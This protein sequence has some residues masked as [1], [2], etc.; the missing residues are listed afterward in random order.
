MKAQITPAIKDIINSLPYNKTVK[1]NAI[2]I[3]V[4]LYNIADTRSNKHGYFPVP[5]EYLTSINVRYYKIMEHF[6]E[7]GLLQQYKR[8]HQDPNDIFN[9]IERRYY[10]TSRGICMRYKF[11]LPTKGEIIEV[12]LEKNKKQFR[13]YDITRTSLEQL[14]YDVKISRDTFGRRVHHSAIQTYK[15][16][17]K[18]Q[19]YALIDAKCS[20]PKLLLNLM[21]EKGIEDKNYIEAFKFDFYTYLVEKLDLNDR[22][23]AK[24]LFMYFLN[25]GGYVPNYKIHN[26]FPQASRFVKSLKNNNYKDSS[27]YLQR[28]EA[29][30]WID[31]LLE[32]IPTDFGLPVH[33]CLI[34]K[35]KDSRKVL[36]YCKSK[37]NNID[38]EVSYL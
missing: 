13:W 14:G 37:Y 6:L 12:N 26:I 17:L 36:E 22:Q 23:A 33:D 8:K 16:D 29:K 30:I 5:S 18:E 27:S 2:K 19:G 32:N 10:D 25:S 24:D 31:D 3:Y 28:I 35:V 1:N 7:K 9:S 4:A 11:L 38:F 34:V 20:Q 15:T 21:L